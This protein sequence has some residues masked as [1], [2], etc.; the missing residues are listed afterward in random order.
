MSEDSEELPSGEMHCEVHFLCNIHV[1]KSGTGDLRY[2][3]FCTS[4]SNQRI[5]NSV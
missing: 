2:K 5:C 3:R 4:G 1:H